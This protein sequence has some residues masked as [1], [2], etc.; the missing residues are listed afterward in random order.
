VAAEETDERR[1]DEL[2]WLDRDREDDDCASTLGS[3]TAA[4]VQP[5]P[6]L[7]DFCSGVDEL[8]VAVAADAFVGV[9]PSGPEATRTAVRT[10]TPSTALPAATVHQR[11]KGERRRCRALIDPP[12]VP[13][14]PSAALP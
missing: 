1:D 3:S 6:T 9:S 7:E 14:D 4:V 2:R 12:P 10:A 11:R 5:S 13:T 8:L